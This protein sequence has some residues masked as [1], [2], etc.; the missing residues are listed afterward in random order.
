MGA[1]SCKKGVMRSHFSHY[2][3]IP[4]STTMKYEGILNDI[5]FKLNSKAEKKTINLEISLSSIK[6]QF[7][8]KKKYG[9]EHFLNQNMMVKKLIN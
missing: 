1:S 5:Y 7:Q 8:T 4:S 6:I 2:S 3:E 9:K